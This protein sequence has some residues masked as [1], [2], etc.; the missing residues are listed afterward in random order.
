[1]VAKNSMPTLSIKI[2]SY[3]AVVWRCVGRRR[4][5]RMGSFIEVNSVLAHFNL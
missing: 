2:S 5:S 3:A 4:G 1:M